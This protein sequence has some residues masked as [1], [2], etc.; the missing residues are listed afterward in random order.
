[1]NPMINTYL[2]YMTLVLIGFFL[3]ERMLNGLLI[4]Y[5]QVLLSSGNKLLIHCI[6]EHKH[7]WRA[8]NKTDGEKITFKLSSK[9]KESLTIPI[10]DENKGMFYDLGRV[11]AFNYDVKSGKVLSP[12][13]TELPEIDRKKYDSLIQRAIMSAAEQFDMLKKMLI[14]IVVVGILV[15]IVGF[16][17][18]KNYQMLQFLVKGLTTK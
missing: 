17:T 10:T 8:S 12:T 5:T 7:Y 3:A 6:A 4:P 16:L 15:L 1:M 9:D 13:F 11:K 14:L 2:I 18:F